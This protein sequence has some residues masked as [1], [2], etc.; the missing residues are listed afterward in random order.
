MSGPMAALLLNVTGIAGAGFIAPFFLVQS[1]HAGSALTGLVVLALPLGMAGASSLGGWLADRWSA[2]GMTVIGTVVIASG[3]ALISP[4]SG[5][6]QPADLM[7]RLC[8]VGV[9]MGLFAG[10]NMAVAMRQAP[11]HL[12][13]TAGAATSLAR[14]LAFALGP[15]LATVPWALSGY[16]VAGMRM[17]A[18]LTVTAA[19]LALAATVAA[20]GM[21]TQ[22]MPC[23]R[24]PT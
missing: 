1:L 19:A 13:G 9:G 12:L 2:R 16:S 14:S 18:A 11:G 5:G 24:D 10:P 4:L 8:L 17:A 7:W 23:W 6:W 3:L 20:W 21:H 15:A 22:R